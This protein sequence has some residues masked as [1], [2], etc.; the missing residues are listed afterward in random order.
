MRILYFIPNIKLLL[1]GSKQLDASKSVDGSKYRFTILLERSAILQEMNIYGVH[2]HRHRV[3]QLQS[4]CACC[5]L[6]SHCPYCKRYRRWINTIVKHMNGSA[7]WYLLRDGS[8]NSGEG[9]GV[10]FFSVWS[11]GH[12]KAPCGS[13]ATPLVGA[14]GAKPRKLLNSGDFIIKYKVHGMVN[15]RNR[16]LVLDVPQR[17]YFYTLIH[18][19]L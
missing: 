17:H 14:Q 19:W 5:G 9:R 7:I 1:L 16:P 3:V 6:K 18:F 12:L 11:R 2:V 13:R 8:R 4:N 10:D 15:R